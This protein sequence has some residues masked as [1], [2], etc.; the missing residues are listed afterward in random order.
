[1]G[2]VAESTNLAIMPETIV[3][4]VKC[5]TICRRKL[6]RFSIYCCFGSFIVTKINAIESGVGNID[7]SIVKW[8]VDF[9]F[10]CNK[11][12]VYK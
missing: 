8:I 4:I 12:F 9:R 1:M 10:D 3:T 7:I 11:G 2:L 5:L 6:I